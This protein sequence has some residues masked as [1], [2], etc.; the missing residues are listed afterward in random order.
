MRRPDGMICYCNPAFAE[1]F[2]KTP[3]ELQG[4]D[5]KPEPVHASPIEKGSG[6]RTRE[7]AFQ[8]RIGQN[9]KLR[10]FAWL[11]LPVRDEKLGGTMTLSV[12]RDIT[13]FKQAERTL[14]AARD[15]AEQA[16]RAKS[17]FLAMVSHEMRTP[18][19]GILGMSQL[20][21]G[22]K[23]TPEQKSYLDAVSNSGSSLLRLIEEMLDLTMI[24]AGRFQLHK[25]TFDL[26]PLLTNVV[27]LM[28]ARAY[29]K[30]IGL[31]LFIAPSVPLQIEGD[32][33]RIRQIL[34]NLIGNAIKFT[35]KGGIAVHCYVKSTPQNHPDTQVRLCFDIADTGQGLSEVDKARVFNEFER[36]DDGNNRKSGG[37]GLGLAI[38]RAIAAQMGGTLELTRTGPNG[39]QFTFELPVCAT[40]PVSEDGLL[41]GKLIVIATAN[42][43]ES[44]CLSMQ[45]SAHGVMVRLVTSVSQAM[46]SW[47]KKGAVPHAILFDSNTLSNVKTALQ[48]TAKRH[49]DRPKFIVMIDP[50][51]RKS[52][53]R[54][55]DCGADSYLIRPVRED[56]LLAILNGEQPHKKFTIETEDIARPSNLSKNTDLAGTRILLAEDNDINAML[57]MAILKKVGA[58][59]DRAM[60]GDD[61][62]KK[63]TEV[64][65]ESKYDFVLMDMHMPVMDGLEAATRIRKW[66][67]RKKSKM[68]TPIFA[69]SADDQADTRAQAFE[70]GMN[71]FL[72]KPI[73][74]TALVEVIL[75][76]TE[77]K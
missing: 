62:F 10:W 52:L 9:I 29:A 25:E 50:A 1:C 55:L 31:G 56:S 68:V 27:E 74:P 35:Q 18:L 54:Y 34:L 33:D 16:N 32:A 65:K 14:D 39:S 57:V 64:E 23:L 44:E 60:D 12:A 38:S 77:A 47:N 70:A 26:K 5:F 59:V 4:T 53:P 22:T 71:R 2:G 6:R 75:E 28:S 46:K 51:K 48:K 17:R 63:F 7:F 36:V 61:A 41:R 43:M 45:L 76:N 37:A 67:K 19:N 69:L 72:I 8:T 24:E 66:E 11:D 15:K 42:K 30:D 58:S 49:A 13:S 21:G 73:D 3:T 20:L 40:A